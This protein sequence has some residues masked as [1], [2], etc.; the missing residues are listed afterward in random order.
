MSVQQ[1]ALAARLTMTRTLFALLVATASLLPREAVAVKRIQAKVNPPEGHGGTPPSRSD[2]TRCSSH[3]RVRRLRAP[4][5]QAQGRRPG[6]PSRRSRRLPCRLHRARNGRW[7]APPPH[8]LLHGQGFS[9]LGP[10]RREALPRAAGGAVLRRHEDLRGDG[11]RREPRRQGRPGRHPGQ[12]G[13]EQEVGD[14]LHQ[15]RS[16]A[17][18]E[19]EGDDVLRADGPGPAHVAVPHQPL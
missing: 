3:W 9:E 2:P 17:R 13:G 16:A 11:R 7:A 5:P 8:G 12:P 18:V 4:E 10:G 6:A 14:E 1:A 15:G 19:Q